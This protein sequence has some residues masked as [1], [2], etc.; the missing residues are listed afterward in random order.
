MRLQ[1][2]CNNGLPAVGGFG[3][4]SVYARDYCNNKNVHSY[5]HGLMS[6]FTFLSV[7][8]RKAFSLSPSGLNEAHSTKLNV[9]L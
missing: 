7:L 1:R 5:I 8:F 9:I 6:N 2:I 3:L 4:A